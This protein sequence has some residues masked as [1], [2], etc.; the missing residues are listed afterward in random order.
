MA[1]MKYLLGTLMKLREAERDREQAALAEL[2]A[3]EQKQASEQAALAAQQR[4]LRQSMARERTGEVRIEQILVAEKYAATLVANA[5]AQKT[6]RERLVSAVEQ[7]RLLLTEADR[8]V[9][10]LEK[11][12]SR[13]DLRAREVE[14][15]REARALDEIAIL[16]SG[17]EP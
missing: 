10:I 9:K 17:R 13:Q 2:L 14:A 3:E 8:Q 4:E 1:H 16:A 5:Q 7:Q 6:A 11:W 12:K 15:R